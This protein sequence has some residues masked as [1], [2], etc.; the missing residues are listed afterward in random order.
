M[1]RLLFGFGNLVDIRKARAIEERP[2]NRLQ[3][4]KNPLRAYCMGIFWNP[5][6]MTLS[7]SNKV[8]G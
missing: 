4:D 8:E 6:L 2:K 5:P 3:R 1:V 7:N